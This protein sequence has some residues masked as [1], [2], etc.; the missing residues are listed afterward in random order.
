MDQ[1]YPDNA[2]NADSLRVTIVPNRP[3][4]QAEITIGRVSIYREGR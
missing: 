2:L 3:V 1:P 4:R